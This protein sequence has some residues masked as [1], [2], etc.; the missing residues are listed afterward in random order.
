[1][2]KTNQIQ[3]KTAIQAEDEK[4]GARTVQPRIYLP[5]LGGEHDLDFP[6]KKQ[7]INDMQVL[8]QFFADFSQF[9]SSIFPNFLVCCPFALKSIE[10]KPSFYFIA[11]SDQ[12]ICDNDKTAP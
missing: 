10:T 3:E 6:H 1:M 9:V 7:L 2:H 4:I 11:L 8:L 12:E 5:W